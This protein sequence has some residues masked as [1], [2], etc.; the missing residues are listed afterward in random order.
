MKRFIGMLNL[1]ALLLVGT[2]A[3]AQ[4]V[5]VQVAQSEEYG[6]YLTDAQ[7]RT[8]YLFVDEETEEQG[9]EQMTEG[10]REVAAD[11]DEECLKA[12]PAFTAE[13]VQAGEGINP[14]LL[15]TTT[16]GD[17]TQVVYNGWPLYYFVRDEEPGQINGQDVH[18]FGGEWYIVSPEG[19]E[20]EDEE[21]EHAGQQQQSLPGIK[22][23]EV[24]GQGLGTFLVDS[25]GR[26]LYL[27]TADSP[28]AGGST[29]YEDCAEKWPPFVVDTEPVTGEGVDA[30][31]LGTLTRRDGEMQ[32]T[33]NGWP[34]YYYQ[35]DE[36]AGDV[37][38][39]DVHGFGGEWYLI[40]PAGEKVEGEEGE[41][42]GGGHH[43]SEGS[44]QAEAVPE[45]LT[46]G[47]ELIAE[48]FTHPVML[49]EPPDD[50]QRLFIADQGGQIWVVAPDG[51]RLEEPF[52]DLQD[53]LVNLRAHYDE[54][55]LLGLAFHPNYAENGR[56]FVYYSAPLR[57]GAPQDFD[58]TSHVSEFTV[59]AADA[60]RADPDS[61]RILLQVDQ[62][63]FNHNAGTLAFGPEDGYLYL[64]LGD[65]GNADDEGTGHVEDWYAEN[66]G[67]NGQ[68]VTEN[69]LGSILRLDVDGGDPYTVPADNPFVDT[70]ALPEQY[71]YGF[72]NPYR[73]SF[74]MA[75]D[76]ALYVGDAGQELWEEIS[77][78]G[79]GGNYGW[80]VKEGTH[81]F[82]SEDP[83]DP[84]VAC[85]ETVGEGSP[86]SGDP[87]I[88]PV[89][90]FR[91]AS[92]PGGGLGVVVV[93]GYVYRGQR[94]PE[95]AGRYLFGTFSRGHTETEAGE[96]HFGGAV[97]VADPQQGEGLWSFGSV[98][99]AGTPDGQ[100]EHFLLSFAQDLEGE[101]Y[102]LVADEHGPMGD[103]G[104]VYR[105]IPASE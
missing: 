65:G 20:V 3:W 30:S 75:G 102:L 97:F 38:G 79:R 34:L 7:G 19:T 49:A 95:L 50:S 57:E 9:P 83:D 41:H 104:K 47:L 53:R 105:L 15:Y 82:D 63:Q 1:T 18:S 16:V 64:S 22:V 61:E 77:R 74:D 51:T 42:E 26:S 39:Q 10:V 8:L 73:F 71:A 62:P 12:W 92:A 78:V 6:A 2:L 52:L 98:R 35:Q 85:P 21:G 28:G 68:D 69:L 45:E 81:C 94:I 89:V 36:N 23:A 48:G 54:R 43:G 27:F 70:E 93:G 14:E 33:Y 84:P 46:I 59:S 32:V 55:G 90:E 72:R 60:N 58:H 96:R 76:H 56:F 4:D 40:T 99:I 103:T 25:S 11:C 24:E 101:V 100:L 66:D 13:T 37:E 88:D 91:N 67:G 87:L 5:T 29:C 44:S 80:N 17:R 31:L 86:R